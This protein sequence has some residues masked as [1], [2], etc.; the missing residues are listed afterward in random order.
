MRRIEMINL[1][2]VVNT[3]HQNRSRLTCRMQHNNRY[4]MVAFLYHRNRQL[5]TTGL[6]GMRSIKNAI[7]RELKELQHD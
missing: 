4:I 6:D 1:R 5:F 3:G 7:K 2:S